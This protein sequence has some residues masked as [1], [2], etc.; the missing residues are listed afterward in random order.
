MLIFDEA[1]S[2][3][4]NLTERAVYTAISTLH[5]EA[6]ILVIAHRLSTVKEADQILVLQ[7]GRIVECGTHETLMRDGT[8]YARLYTEDDRRETEG[9]VEPVETEPGHARAS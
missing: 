3:L 7:D 8:F 6:I 5:R 2:A 1:T 4:D 9:T